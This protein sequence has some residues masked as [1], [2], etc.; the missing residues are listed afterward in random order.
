MELLYLLERVVK[1]YREKYDRY[2]P[3]LSIGL[4]LSSFTTPVNN[5]FRGNTFHAESTNF[6]RRVIGV[7]C[8]VD[9][10]FVV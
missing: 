6:V 5:P 9:A 4:A 2:I 3:Q 10:D 8:I 7:R 1:G